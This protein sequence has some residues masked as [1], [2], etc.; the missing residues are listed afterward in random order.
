MGSAPITGKWTLDGST[1]ALTLETISGQPMAQI[2]KQ[3]D[4][5]KSLLTKATPAQREALDNIDKPHNL[6]LSEDGKTL[7]GTGNNHLSLTKQSS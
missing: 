7:S 2:K 4:Q 1:V 3:I 5:I 6:T